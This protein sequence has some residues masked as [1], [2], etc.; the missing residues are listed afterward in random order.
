MIPLSV[1]AIG[2]G[3]YIRQRKNLPDVR[4]KAAEIPIM[5]HIFFSFYI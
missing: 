5:N 4:T 2:V 3:N 1:A